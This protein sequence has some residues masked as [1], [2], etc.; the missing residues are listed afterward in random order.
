MRPGSF[1]HIYLRCAHTGRLA[2]DP[3]LYLVKER[4]LRTEQGCDDRF[5]VI[6]FSTPKSK[7]GAKKSRTSEC[8]KVL[9]L[10]QIFPSTPSLYCSVLLATFPLWKDRTLKNDITHV[11]ELN[12]VYDGID[13]K[14]VLL[15]LHTRALSSAARVSS[16]SSYTSTPPRT[17]CISMMGVS[18]DGI[19]FPSHGWGLLHQETPGWRW[20]SVPS[21][22]GTRQL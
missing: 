15:Y 22:V 7:G 16:I 1:E 14:V 20:G 13:T 3:S 6:V 11:R 19:C 17:Y 4:W 9:S 21:F 10:D 12:A 5:S 18:R 2:V 8:R